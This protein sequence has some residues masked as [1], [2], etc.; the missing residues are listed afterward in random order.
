MFVVRIDGKDAFF[1]Y[2]KIETAPSPA[3]QIEV[4]E[5]YNTLGIKTNKITEFLRKKGFA[6]QAGHPL[7][8]VTLYPPLAWKA[9]MGWHGINGIVIGS[10]YGP[11]HRLSAIY[12]SIE[13]LPFFE[14]E[15]EHAWVEKYCENCKLCVKECPPGALF[16]EPKTLED[17]RLKYVED[18]KCFPYF[19]N[20]NGCS[21]CIKVC[22]FNRS[23]YW[24]L[25]ATYEKK[26][27]AY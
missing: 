22:P 23:D 12:T 6:A 9:G 27:S 24:K 16:G 14:G 15:N 3:C 11:R 2:D 25:K 8:G 10:E 18:E 19:S 17:G 21:I 20:Y 7:G 5:T 26:V 13:N 1:R 4:T